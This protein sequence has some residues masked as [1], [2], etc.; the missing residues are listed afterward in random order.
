MRPLHAGR[1]CDAWIQVGLE[2]FQCLKAD[3]DR[4]AAD[5]TPAALVGHDPVSKATV[6][7]RRKSV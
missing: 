1:L 2:L 6:R 4:E 3:R 5:R 7:I